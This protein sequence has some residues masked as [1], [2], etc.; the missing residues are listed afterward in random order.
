MQK[1]VYIKEDDTP[2]TSKRELWR[3][4]SDILPRAIKLI[5]ENKVVIEGRK[6]KIL[7]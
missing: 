6:V 5:S 3:K 1:A 2:E 4:R 7:D